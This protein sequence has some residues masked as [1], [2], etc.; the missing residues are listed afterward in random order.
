MEMKNEVKPPKKDYWAM[1]KAYVKQIGK[2]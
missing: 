1:F 2:G